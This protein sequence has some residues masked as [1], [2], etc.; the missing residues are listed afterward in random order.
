M[1]G[2]SLKIPG[3]ARE[4]KDGLEITLAHLQENNKLIQV[5]FSINQL[6]QHQ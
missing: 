2:S 5:I 4:P 3:R 1:L 6:E